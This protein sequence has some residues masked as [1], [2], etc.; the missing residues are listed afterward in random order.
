METL[1]WLILKLGTR[2]C[3]SGCLDCFT[4]SSSPNCLLLV[5]PC[6]VKRNDS[7][8][9]L[10]SHPHSSSCPHVQHEA[11]ICAWSALDGSYFALYT[12]STKT[13]TWYGKQK[14]LEFKEMRYWHKLQKITLAQM[15]K[16]TNIHSIMMMYSY[17]ACICIHVRQLKQ[18]LDMENKSIWSLTKWDID[19]S[20]KK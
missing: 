8:S 1:S 9:L 16:D 15:H 12:Q 18:T 14:H 5:T 19:I 17:T 7:I 4:N 11:W 2:I 13:N 6:K 20:S 10:W 3:L